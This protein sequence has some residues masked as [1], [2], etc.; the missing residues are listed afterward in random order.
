MSGCADTEHAA[1]DPLSPLEAVVQ[2]SL[3][4]VAGTL[5][6][7][8]RVFK[9][10]PYA[11]PP[12]AELRFAR[13]TT[14]PGW[15][16]PLPA[17]E[18]GPGCPQPVSPISSPGDED[19]L[20]LNVW[21]PNRMGTKPVMVWFHGGA[22]YLGSGGNSI[23]DGTG[24]ASKGDVVVVTLNYRL[25]L[26]GFLP[27]MDAAYQHTGM[28][29]LL[30]Q[31]F[32][33]KWVREN[34]A[35]F[36]GD[37]NN[38][39]IFGESAGGF[40]VCHHMG[41]PSSDGLYH[42]AIIQSGAGCSDP[43]PRAQAE[44][45]NER[46]WSQSRCDQTEVEGRLACARELDVET[47]LE[48][49]VSMPTNAL[50]LTSVQPFASDAPILKG[51]LSRRLD[52]SSNPVPIMIGSNQDEMTLFTTLGYVP[53]QDEADYEAAL[54]LLGL[55]E[56][57]KSA[58]RAVYN[59]ANY[60]SLKKAI[61]ALGTDTV[62]TCPA[63]RFARA[64]GEASHP[65]YLY[66]FQLHLGTGLSSLGATHGA[67]IPYVFD[68]AE[69]GLGGIP[70][71]LDID[72]EA[73]DRFQRLWTDF[74]RTGMPTPSLSWDAFDSANQHIMMM[75]SDWSLATNPFTERCALLPEVSF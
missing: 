2:T 72:A 41:M 56:S 33:L 39:T 8:V 22:F 42:R 70:L 54:D 27:L 61:E 52:G 3:G 48:I 6:D 35:D 31:Q 17:V 1:I 69:A 37:P 32:A 47:L 63:M 43:A 16:T 50:G 21:A 13:P 25:G 11:A 7:D 28:L 40:S 15:S 12:L 5:D 73:V 53:V 58:V 65:V 59:E 20:T 44:T 14:H 62:F 57:S 68:T 64:S 66:Q 45:T 10:L 34:I 29:G 30:D 46:F 26:L 38:V 49:Q 67:E 19:C 4:P 51:G 9:G 18:F 71:T 36:G 74:A 23:Y 55:S 75:G 60:G 24:L